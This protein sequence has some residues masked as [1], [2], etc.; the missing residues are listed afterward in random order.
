MG[1]ILRTAVEAGGGVG[2]GMTVGAGTEGRLVAAG[3]GGFG[4]AWAT[5][6]NAVSETWVGARTAGSGVAGGDGSSVSPH[7]TTANRTV[8]TSTTEKNIPRRVIWIAPFVFEERSQPRERRQGCLAC[9]RRRIPS[10]CRE[11]KKPCSE[12]GMQGCARALMQ[13][14]SSKTQNMDD[15][16][17]PGSP[18]ELYGSTVAGQRRTLTGFPF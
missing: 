17:G 10:H 11:T 1:V 3:T 6:A 7:A 5:G 4:V 15:G 12:L 13:C 2:L 14:L 16:S 18:V 9:A 8:D